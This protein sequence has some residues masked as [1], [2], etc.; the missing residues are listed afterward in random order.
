MTWPH[1]AFQHKASI[2]AARVAESKAVQPALGG[3]GVNTACKYTVMQNTPR[4]KRRG[5]ILNG[6]S[7]PA[8]ADRALAGRL[9]LFW[10]LCAPC[11]GPTREGHA[12]PLEGGE[13]QAHRD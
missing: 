8:G 2:P 13:A 7:T 12:A 5:E 9:A 10:V 3:Y 6:H 1:A 4:P 11:T